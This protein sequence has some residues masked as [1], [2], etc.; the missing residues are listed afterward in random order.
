MLGISFAEFSVE[1]QRTTKSEEAF[2]R[3][4]DFMKYETQSMQYFVNNQDKKRMREGHLK[5]SFIYMLIDP[6]LSCNLPG[7]SAVSCKISLSVCGKNI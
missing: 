2:L 1:L 3:I 6:R 5:Q 7:E 4:Q